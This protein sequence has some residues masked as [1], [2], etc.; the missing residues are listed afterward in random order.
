MVHRLGVY[1]H[2]SPHR[3]DAFETIR[4]AKNPELSRGNIPLR[5]VPTRW[6]S[7]EAAIRRAILLQDTILA[8]TNRYHGDH[9]PRFTKDTFR[10]LQ[11]I[12]PALEIFAQLTA[13]YSTVEANS[14]R[15]LTDLHVAITTLEDMRSR[16]PPNRQPSFRAAIAKLHKYMDRM[17]ENDW[18]C[19]AFALDAN[20]KEAG[21]NKLFVFYEREHR[22]SD[23]VQFIRTQLGRYEVDQPTL[24][25]EQ[26][27]QNVRE[28]SPNPFSS[29][30]S[31]LDDGVDSTGGI[32]AWSEY[33]SSF[34]LEKDLN[35]KPNESVLQFWKRQDRGNL[36]LKPLARVARDV[37]GIASSSVSVERL[38][39]NPAM[40]LAGS[41]DLYLL[42]YWLSK[43]R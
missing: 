24:D 10:A 42:L 7:T 18:V 40:Y 28:T 9:C 31:F 4:K 8:F 37:L 1:V 12:L 32:D 14:Y 34:A 41:E 15:I 38:S 22:T 26:L 20:V 21:L 30:V 33:N 5:D 29:F 2:S 43:L 6:N 19:A 16:L 3:R 17:L 39:L 25:S 27:V 13:R 23:V 35:R 11:A 36:K